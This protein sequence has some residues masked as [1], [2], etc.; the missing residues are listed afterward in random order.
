M[1]TKQFPLTA[2]LCLLHCVSSDFV[3][4]M[5][6]GHFLSSVCFTI[7]IHRSSA[8][9]YF[10]MCIFFDTFP[11]P[12]G[13]AAIY[14]EPQTIF[15]LFLHLHP[16]DCSI[17][18]IFHPFNI[19]VIIIQTNQ[20]TWLGLQTRPFSHFSYIFHPSDCSSSV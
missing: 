14:I 1:L 17:P 4:K 7:P 5:V 12:L 16:S 15:T 6:S 13:S 10:C 20:S 9:I 18:H 2:L 8:G 11:L 3:D 19:I